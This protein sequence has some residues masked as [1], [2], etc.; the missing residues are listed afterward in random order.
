MYAAVYLAGPRWNMPGTAP[1]VRAVPGLMVV[2][3]PL[4]AGPPNT[5]LPKLIPE[6]ML[7]K[8]M[9]AQVSNGTAD[10]NQTSEPAQSAAY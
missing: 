2:T 4:N 7:I 3:A 6:D 1:K 9:L 8:G 5:P 10:N